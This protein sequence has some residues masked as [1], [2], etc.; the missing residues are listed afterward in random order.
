GG[1][2]YVQGIA[3]SDGS[4]ADPIFKLSN[5]KLFTVG[6]FEE[7][8]LML[9]IP[10]RGREG[11]ATNTIT[12]GVQVQRSGSSRGGFAKQAG[13]GVFYDRGKE[14]A[15]IGGGREERFKDGM[16]HRTVPEKPWPSDGWVE[17][18]IVR[19]DLKTGTLAAYVDKDPADGLDGEKIVED[20]I[21][22]YKG[23]TRAKAQ[24]WIGGWSTEAQEFDVQI[25]DIR[26]IRRKR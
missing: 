15:R 2:I 6:S 18:R 16:V 21:G 12:F 25:K 8:R 17:V 4:I 14:A 24:L 10:P 3:K 9:R 1:V 5:E 26:V 22:S 13:I 11:T 20:I 23:K 7:V 19:Q